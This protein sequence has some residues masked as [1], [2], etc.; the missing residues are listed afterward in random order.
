M[1]TKRPQMV[2]EPAPVPRSRTCDNPECRTRLQWSTGRGR[3]PLYCS[4]TCRKRA[5]SVAGK[6]VRAIH[7]QQRNL[8]E[9]SLT[10][11]A[12]RIARTELAQ[13][14]WLL[15]MYP[16]SARGSQRAGSSPA[17]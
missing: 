17:S 8:Q 3:P 5:V 6:L 13:L 4:S 14:E 10:Y 7:A 1:V 11:R 16:A 9:T 15:S 12:E 2:R